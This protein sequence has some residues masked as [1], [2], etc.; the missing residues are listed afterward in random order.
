[1]PHVASLSAAHLVHK[2]RATSQR[3][4]NCRYKE[5]QDDNSK[6]ELDG[7]EKPDA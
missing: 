5:S 7:E 1:M 4:L 2:P 6:E 3:M